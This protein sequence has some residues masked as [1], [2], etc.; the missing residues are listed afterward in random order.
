MVISD[1]NV[2]V[3]SAFFR[4]NSQLELPYLHQPIFYGIHDGDCTDGK[5]ASVSLIQEL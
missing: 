2:N 1:G 3:L 5:L 4:Q